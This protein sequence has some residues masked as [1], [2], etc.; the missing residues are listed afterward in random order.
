VPSPAPARRQAKAIGAVVAN[1]QRGGGGC[2]GS[3]ER[4]CSSADMRRGSSGA[5]ALRAAALSGT[6]QAVRRGARHLLP[7]RQAPLG[8]DGA[9]W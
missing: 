1:W 4:L 7:G 9:I 6:T 8:C 2:G 3:A 5:S